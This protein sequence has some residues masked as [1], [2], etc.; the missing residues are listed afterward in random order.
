MAGHAPQTYANHTRLDPLFHGFILPVAG[1][2]VVVAIW[3]A[4]KNFGW[5]SAWWVVI[6]IAAVVAVLKI[7]LYALRVQDRLIR[8]EERLRLGQLLKEPARSRIDELTEAQLI[9]LRFACDA[10]L[11]ALTEKA[12]G[13]MTN[14]EI[15]KAVGS[16]RP[17]YF[18]V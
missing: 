8:L 15:K 13:G 14:R 4:V 16:W 10:E 6:S 3:N 1:I 18:R 7:R 11:P 9:G 12:L 2:S 5:G 17:D